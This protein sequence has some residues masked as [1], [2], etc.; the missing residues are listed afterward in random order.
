[1]RCELAKRAGQ[2]WTLFLLLWHRIS[3]PPAICGIS[4][5]QSYWS[6]WRAGQFWTLL[7]LPCH[8]ISDSPA[9]CGISRAR[10]G[11][12]GCFGRLSAEA[13]A[14]CGISEHRSSAAL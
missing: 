10:E 1:M 6:C 12:P 14:I 9:I 5:H 7:R 8:R 13:P 4:R 2:F 11:V 3:D